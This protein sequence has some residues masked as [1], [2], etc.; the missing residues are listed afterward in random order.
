VT[1]NA[2]PTADIIGTTIICIGSSATITGTGGT[3]YSWNSGST[4]TSITTS[5]VANITFTVTVTDINGCKDTASQLVT[6]N[7]QPTAAITG[8]TVICI[9]TTATLTGTGGTSYSW[10]TG[11]TSL[12]ITQ[13][14]TANS[15]Y[16]VTI[17]DANGCKDTTSQLV[18]VNAQPAASASATTPICV[19]GVSSLTASGGTSYIWNTGETTT[20]ISVSPITTT[21]FTVTATD[22]NGCKD[23]ANVTVIVNA[24]TIAGLSGATDICI[25]GNTTLTAT[26]GQTYSWNTSQTTVSITV[27]PTTNTAYTV[28]AIIVGDGCKDTTSTTVTVA[29]QPS[30]GIIGITTICNG[31]STTLSG[32][33]GTS[34]MWNDGATSIS[35]SVNPSTN[36]VY[37]VTVTGSGGCKD[38]ASQLVTVNGQPTAVITGITDICIGGSTTLNGSPG[39]FYTWSNG[40]TAAGITVSPTN[41]T[42]YT[43]TVTDGNGCKDTASQLVTVNAQPSASITGTTL[44]CVGFSA[45]LTSSSATSYSWNTGAATI[46]ITQ[47]PT[48]NTTYTVTI[49]DGNGCK[50]TASQLVTVN[51][52]LTASITGTT[53]ICIGLSATITGSNGTNYS[54][55]TGASTVSIT[56]SPTSNTTYTVTITGS[57]GCKDTASQLV[58]VN[59]QPTVAISGNTSIC[60]G[61]STNLQATGGISYLWNSSETSQT[62]TVSPSTSA[63]YTVTIMDA[64]GCQDIASHSIS[65]ADAM[66]ITTSSAD[67]SCFGGNDGTAA[68]SVSGGTPTYSFIWPN[69]ATTANTNLLYPGVYI[70]TVTDSKGCIGSGTVDIQEPTQIILNTG[71]S[72]ATCASSNGSVSV[73]ASGG[74][75]GYTYQWSTGATTSAI[76]NS[77]SFGIYTVTVTDNKSCVETAISAVGDASGPTASITANDESCYGSCDGGINLTVTGGAPNYTFNWSNGAITEDISSLCSGNYS[78]EITD[79]NGCK[80]IVSGISINSPAQIVSNFDAVLDTNNMNKVHFTDKSTGLVSE[81]FWNFDDGKYSFDQN[82]SYIYSEAGFYN[83][84]LT[85]MDSTGCQDLFCQYVEVGDTATPKCAAFFINDS[86]A[87]LHIAFSDSSLGDI[88]SRYWVFGDGSSS[89]LVNPDHQ[90]SVAGYY[91]ICL[92]VYDTGSA[93]M[94]TYCKLIQVNAATVDSTVCF[95]FANFT[96]FPDSNNNVT[97]NNQSADFTDSYW[98]FGDGATSFDNNP[99]HSYSQPGFYYICLTVFDSTNDCQDIMC[100]FIEIVDQTDSITHDCFAFFT[101]YVDQTALTAYFA[102]ESGGTFTDWYWNFGDG[103]TSFDQNPTHQYAKSGYYEVCLTIFDSVSGCQATYCDVVTLYDSTVVDCQAEFTFYPDS[104]GNIVH[105]TDASTGTFTNWN[106]DFGD[107]NVS[108]DQDPNHTYSNAGYYDVCLTVYD[109]VSEC[110]S[111]ACDN[112]KIGGDSAITIDCYVFFTYYPDANNN[113]YFTDESYTANPSVTTVFWNFGDGSVSTSKDS[114]IV[115]N[116]ASSGYF[117]V[118]L[119]IYDMSTQCME[120]Y[121]VSIQVGGDSAISVDCKSKFSFYPK[122]NLKVKFKAEEEGQV[123]NWSWDFGDGS[124]SNQKNP[125]HQYNNAGY[126]DVCLT[127]FND[128]DSCMDVDCQVIQ[129]T[130]STKVNCIAFFN[131]MIDSATNTVTFKDKSRAGGKIDFYYWNFGDFTVANN[132]KNPS[133]TYSS[134]GYYKVCVTIYRGTECQN[135][136]CEVLA[137]GDVSNSVYAQFSYYTDSVTAT[138]YFK[139]QSLGNVTSWNW[140]FGDNQFSTYQNPGHTYASDSLYLVCLNVK[141]AAGVTHTSCRNIR[142]RNSLENPCL[143]SCVWPG[144]ANN[145]LEANHYDLMYLGLKYGEQGPKRDSTSTRWIGHFANDWSSQLPNGMNTKYTDCN[146]D[147]VVDTSDIKALIENFAMSHPFQPGKTR[148]YNPS[149]PDLYFEVLT[150]DIAPGAEVEVSIKSDLQGANFDLY[151]IAFEIELDDRYIQNGSIVMAYDSSWLGTQGTDMITY[152]DANYN[153]GMVSSGLTRIDQINQTGSGTLA[154]LKFTIPA[155]AD[156]SGGLP[157]KTTSFYGMTAAGDSIFFNSKADT[158]VG[159][160]DQTR[161]FEVKKITVYPNPTT[162]IVAFDLPFGGF[163]YDLEIMNTFGQIVY[164]NNY[165][166]GG[167]KYLDLKNLS[168]GIYFLNIKSKDVIYQQKLQIAR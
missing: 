71:S 14:P 101:Q 152:E 163:Q 66:T 23:T 48:V 4:A 89:N 9:G 157:I 74:A 121:C 56:R 142:V 79:A 21:T 94:E 68:V 32:T 36:T 154:I 42:T 162:G 53:V 95:T 59:A 99:L 107:G 160:D 98:D 118:C 140:D 76:N 31:F 126:Y 155:T 11:A 46:S 147:G 104:T 8:T 81:W 1:V 113:V 108:S 93:C 134:G 77:L 129:I 61:S 47:S 168:G 72:D 110:M 50:D 26:G 5:P 114:V 153:T 52:Q 58:T 12:S 7:A 64:N 2:Q 166:R 145:S 164:R 149:N 63:S 22:G 86:I 73:T 133:H 96:F 10:N 28:T 143:F 65:I 62:I 18:T 44:I 84:C 123:S 156:V 150:P 100:D 158:V 120:E 85:V 109:S 88:T 135:T 54:W 70:V 39:P 80:A 15:T 112:I 43:L 151:G 17:T 67:V 29:S 97:F 141:N 105:F 159:I 38:T 139:D 51:A 115:H 40:A 92:T 116:Y 167:R 119:T 83:V 90:Y 34:Y 122:P 69:G 78:V 24:K 146:G 6:V 127:V 57:N 27:S 3:S 13:S 30:A 25:G 91:E 87:P 19:G 144:D 45:T 60:S 165:I 106:W 124:V 128:A 41:N 55:N 161:S 16:T 82:T 131:F 111:T 137:V 125:A 103:R 132:E 49:T 138:A 75:G 33:G 117:N 102:D 148:A 35:I 20:P 130:D 37:T 136:Y